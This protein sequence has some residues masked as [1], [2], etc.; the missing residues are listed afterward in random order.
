[1]AVVLLIED[2]DSQR[3]VAA[4]AL[5]KAGHTVH[6]APDGPAGLLSARELRPEAIVCDV[7]MPGMNGYEVVATLRKDAELAVLP[8]EKWQKRAR[9]VS[10]FRGDPAPRVLGDRLWLFGEPLQ[11]LAHMRGERV[12]VFHTPREF[13]GSHKLGRSRILN[14]LGT[15]L[16]REGHLVVRVSQVEQ[17]ATIESMRPSSSGRKNARIAAA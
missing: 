11:Q 1:M 6:E 15:A 7:M 4:F 12:V 13:A 3:F 14:E 2:D 9:A 8:D 16:T 5:R 10:M 17:N